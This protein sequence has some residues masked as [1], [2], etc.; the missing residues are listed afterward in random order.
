MNQP[1][2]ILEPKQIAELLNAPYKNTD[3]HIRDR[4]MLAVL[5]STGLRVSE[6]TGINVEDIRESRITVNGK[7]GKYR[8]VLLSDVGKERL[9][10]WLQVRYER[11]NNNPALFTTVNGKNRISVR[12][13]QCMV[14]NYAESV[15]L[16]GVH[17][18][19]IRHCFAVDALQNGADLR[20]VQMLLGHSSPK[21][22]AI[23]LALSDKMIEE[24]HS[25]YHNE[26][27]VYSN[28]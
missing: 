21:T 6:L 19:T 28:L 9:N 20:Q 26:S 16:F 8:L 14:K 15:D 25:K 17:T 13:V 27:E 11:D 12:T 24:A 18:H 2:K 4:A 3:K 10:R 22:T 1:F 5:F 23:Y 7:G